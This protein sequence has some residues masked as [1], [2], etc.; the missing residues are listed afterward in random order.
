MGRS[1]P[2]PAPSA[3]HKQGGRACG[4]QWQPGCANH[5]LN[6]VHDSEEREKKQVPEYKSC[7]LGE[8]NATYLGK[9]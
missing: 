8:Q 1:M 9:E 3:I 7:T 2:P 5:V 6:A 4:N